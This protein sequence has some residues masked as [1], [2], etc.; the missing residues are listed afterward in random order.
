MQLAETS[1]HGKSA[2]LCVCLTHATLIEVRSSILSQKML[3]RELYAY[4][5]MQ[6]FWL[7][8]CVGRTA[9]L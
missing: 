9:T 7:P 4:F 1:Q 2:R 3:Y 6:S 5:T 8:S